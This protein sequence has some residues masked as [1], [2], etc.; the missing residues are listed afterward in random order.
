MDVPYPVV[1][2]DISKF[3]YSRYMALLC[4]AILKAL[5]SF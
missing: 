1:L 2:Y 5:P 3:D 4:N